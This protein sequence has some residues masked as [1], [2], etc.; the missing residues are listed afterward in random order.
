ME[1][2]KLKKLIEK[3]FL[4]YFP[5]NFRYIKIPDKI[6][7]SE[8]SYIDY[9]IRINKIQNTHSRIEPINKAISRI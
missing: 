5:F 3:E 7:Y 8:K 1:E 6:S 9:S 4:K 2:L